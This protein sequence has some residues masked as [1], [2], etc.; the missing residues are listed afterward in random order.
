MEPI[1]DTTPRFGKIRY[2]APELQ[3]AYKKHMAYAM[4]LSIF[5]TV[6]LVNVLRWFVSEDSFDPKIPPKQIRIFMYSE[7]EMP[8]PIGN[9]N[10]GMTAYPFLQQQETPN[11]LAEAAIIPD[12]NKKPGRRVPVLRQFA[13]PIGGL[14]DAMPSDKYSDERQSTRDNSLANIPEDRHDIAGGSGYSADPKRKG[15]VPVAGK[16]G[17]PPSGFD[18]SGVGSSS[19]PTAGGMPL[20]FGSGVDGEGGGSGY[21]LQWGPGLVR[22]KLSGTLP[23]YP[24]GVNTGGQVQILAFVYPD[25]TVKSVQPQQKV[26]ARLEEAAMNAVRSWIFEA[27]PSSLE[28]VDQSCTIT[29]RFKLK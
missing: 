27:L 4:L 3:R 7:M 15:G 17:E 28:Q 10:F 24:A 26:N 25:G 6:M 19:K 5:L 29:F 13:G 9:G 11:V 1:G 16:T 12:R 21:S 8:Q 22:R 23:K 2:G 18:R 14:P 20:G